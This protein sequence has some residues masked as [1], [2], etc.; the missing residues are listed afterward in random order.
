MGFLV[1]LVLRKEK[2]EFKNLAMLQARWQ[3]IDA[4]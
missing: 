4:K 1:C 3:A 2:V